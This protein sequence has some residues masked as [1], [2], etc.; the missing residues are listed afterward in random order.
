[1]AA[2]D[3]PETELRRLFSGYLDSIDAKD[4]SFIDRCFA[5]DARVLA[6][7]ERDRSSYRA[8][9]HALDDERRATHE[10]HALDVQLLG[11]DVAV[12]WGAYDMHLWFTGVPDAVDKALNF[13][14]VWRR[15]EGA[16]RCLVLHASDREAA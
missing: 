11:D 14:S 2:V 15:Q 10:I 5:T 7:I 4:P 16:W 12:V 6:E 3:M 1:M 13:S 9:Y 8:M